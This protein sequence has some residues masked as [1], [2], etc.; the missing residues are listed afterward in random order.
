[1]VVYPD[2]CASAL[3]KPQHRVPR[4]GS[5]LPPNVVPPPC[6]FLGRALSLLA[7]S[8]VALVAVH[9]HAY[10]LKLDI[11]QT[12]VGGD[13][14]SVVYTTDSV[15]DGDTLNSSCSSEVSAVSPTSQTF[16]ATDT[17]FPCSLDCN[18]DTA[19]TITYD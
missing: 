10:V 9:G 1:M 7:A 4:S 18:Q 15:D 13:L 16:A 12:T 8:T 17:T 14:N 5:I 11:L 3:L 2:A 6:R 19:V